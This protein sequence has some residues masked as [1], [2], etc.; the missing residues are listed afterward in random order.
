MP[1]SGITLLHKVSNTLYLRF[2]VIFKLLHTHYFLENSPSG[3][4][5]PYC[6]SD[7]IGITTPVSSLPPSPPPHKQHWGVFEFWRSETRELFQCE[8]IRDILL[9]KK[10]E[11]C[12]ARHTSSLIPV[13]AL[14]ES[15]LKV[16]WNV[17]RNPHR[18]LAYTIWTGSPG[19]WRNSVKPNEALLPL[20]LD[21]P[22]KRNKTSSIL[23]L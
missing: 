10:S 11:N 23:F 20:W 3:L 2:H 19:I 7:Q 16:A 5:S 8:N 21:S 13:H 14:K 18:T 1:A 6:F 15:I 17:T 9:T 22:L 12:G 4:N